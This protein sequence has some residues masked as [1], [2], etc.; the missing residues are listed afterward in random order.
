M[1]VRAVI[2]DAWHRF[3]GDRAPMQNAQLRARERATLGRAMIR[4]SN[5]GQDVHLARNHKTDA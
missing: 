3:K 2:K 5:R 1:K 4:P